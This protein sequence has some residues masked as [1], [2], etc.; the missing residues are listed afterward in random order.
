LVRLGDCE[1]SRVLT[2]QSQIAC[3]AAHADQQQVRS[4]PDPEDLNRDPDP[5][6]IGAVRLGDCE[7]P[8]LLGQFLLI[9]KSHST[10]TIRC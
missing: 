2:Q 5:W 1:R 7:R 6:D 10:G 8:C 4:V 9:K 3:G